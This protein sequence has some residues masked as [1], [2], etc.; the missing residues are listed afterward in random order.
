MNLSHGFLNKS[1]IVISLFSIHFLAAQTQTFTSIGIGIN[2]SYPLH[3]YEK[4]GESK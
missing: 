4:T 1:F 2:P 3:I